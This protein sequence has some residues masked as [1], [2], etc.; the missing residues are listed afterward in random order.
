MEMNEQKNHLEQI[1]NQQKILIDEINELSNSI[2][3]KKEQAIKLQ[4]IIE[5]LNSNLNPQDTPNLET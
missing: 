4:G 2:N 3:I 1:I 5:Y